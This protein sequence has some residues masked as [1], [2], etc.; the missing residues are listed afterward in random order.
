[1]KNIEAILTDAGVEL[2][3]DQKQKINDGIKE[4]YKTVA[5]YQKQK[6]K[7][8]TLEETLKEAQESLKKFDGVDAA[9][10]KEEIEALNKTIEKNKSEYEAKI[11]DRD[12]TD[13]IEKAIAAAKGKNAKAIKALLDMEALKGSKNQE[14]D[15]KKAIEELTAA[16][17]SKMLFGEPEPKKT[18]TGNPIGTVTKD[19]SGAQT[20]TLASALAAHYNKD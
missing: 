15:I 11:A 9:K 6:E 19:Q 4:N 18:G 2:T 20:E 12:F 7:I 3:D 16:E 8:E 13:T 10:M 14:A 5:D 1:M 17:D